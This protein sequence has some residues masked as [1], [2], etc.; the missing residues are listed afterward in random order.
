MYIYLWVFSLSLSPE[1]VVKRRSKRKS[2]FQFGKFYDRH[3]S[4]CR[5]CMC[6]SVYP[7]HLCEMYLSTYRVFVHD[8]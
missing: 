4:L 8:R 6:A 7:S 5:A 3:L 2:V 1:K